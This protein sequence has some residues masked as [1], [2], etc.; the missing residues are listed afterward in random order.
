MPVAS[1]SPALTDPPVEGNLGAVRGRGAF[2]P[3]L[4]RGDVGGG[5]SPIDGF[6][7]IRRVTVSGLEWRSWV[8]ECCCVTVPSACAL[9]HGV[10][11]A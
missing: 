7:L 3:P 5:D 9:A 10:A 1:C 11:G 4:H 2:L 6:V 8:L